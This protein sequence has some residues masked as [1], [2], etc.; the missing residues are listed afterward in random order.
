VPILISKMKKSKNVPFK[1]FIP[2]LSSKDALVIILQ[3]AFRAEDRSKYY[4][5][6][7]LLC[8]DAI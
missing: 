7:R 8:K 5:L 3:Y 4:L 6:G 2:S 1:P